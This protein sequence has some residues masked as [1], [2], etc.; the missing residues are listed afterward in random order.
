[1]GF[2]WLLR[3][4]LDLGGQARVNLFIGRCKLHHIQGQ[5]TVP[6]RKPALAPLN[7]LMVK[8]RTYAPP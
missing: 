2:G 1:M 8:L 7:H 5:V 3:A 4:A 6:C